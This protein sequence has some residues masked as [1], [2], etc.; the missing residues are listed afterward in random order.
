MANYFEKKDV[1]TL[2]ESITLDKIT[3]LP[4]IILGTKSCVSVVGGDEIFNICLPDKETAQQIIDAFEAYFK[5]RIGNNLAPATENAEDMQQV[6]KNSCL[7]IDVKLDLNKFED[8]NEA[9][10]YF[11]TAFHQA[12]AN[13]ARKIK[14]DYKAGKIKKKE[15]TKS[16]Q[17]ENVKS[18]SN[19]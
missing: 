10:A 16:N 19:Q 5:C 15:I 14:A 7:G 12:L 1:E 2:K 6:L 11:Q 13:V 3:Q 4:S 9:E 18:A 8:Q 17:K